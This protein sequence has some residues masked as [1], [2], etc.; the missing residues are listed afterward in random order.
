MRAS[1]FLAC[2]QR[3]RTGVGHRSRFGY[4]VPVIQTELTQQLRDP[5]AFEAHVVPQRPMKKIAQG[6]VGVGGVLIALKIFVDIFPAITGDIPWRF[7]QHIMLN[8]TAGSRSG[9]VSWVGLYI[10]PVLLLLGVIL[11]LVDRS[12]S[13]TYMQTIHQ[14]FTESGYVA[15]QLPLNFGLQNGKKVR[16]IG[17]VAERNQSDEEVGQLHQYLLQRFAGLDKKEVRRVRTLLNGMQDNAYRVDKFFKDVNA[18][19]YIGFVRESQVVAVIP[20]KDPSK[21]PQILTTK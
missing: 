7:V 12:S 9:I 8:P 18:P 17:L 16:E 5:A 15:T 21:A 20:A 3:F 19:G 4:Y 2:S 11:L 13:R 14:R 1:H 6:L 10:A